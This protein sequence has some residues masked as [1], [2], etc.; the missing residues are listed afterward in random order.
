MNSYKTYKTYKTY[1]NLILLL[2]VVLCG[3]CYLS[4]QIGTFQINNIFIPL[5]DYFFTQKISAENLILAEIRLPR[6]LLAIL[7]GFCLALSGAALQGLLQN[8]LAEPSLLGTSQAAALG[9]VL[10]FYFQQQ[11]ST[12]FLPIFALLFSALSLILLLFLSGFFRQNFHNFQ[13]IQ[14]LQNQIILSGLAISTI[15]GALLSAALNFAPNPYAMQE[16]VFWLLGSVAN[17]NFDDVFLLI[18]AYIFGFCLIFGQ[19]NSLN[20]MTLGLEVS[21]T[22]GINIRYVMLQIIVAVS[23]LVGTSVAICGTIGFVGLITPHIVRNL[24]CVG[25]VISKSLIPAMLL[26]GILML[27]ADI[28]VRLLALQTAMQM[29]GELK[30]GVI[31]AIIGMPFFLQ[32]IWKNK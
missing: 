21:Q 12:L 4:L 19:R 22:L 9:A 10:I 26:G 1:K 13:N 27:A 29:Y 14:N 15:C 25:N 32:M 24:D 5:Y 30:I 31:T 7:V 2:V 23:V 11:F 6:T 8:S 16:L 28:L 17:R 18:F 3:L 20:A